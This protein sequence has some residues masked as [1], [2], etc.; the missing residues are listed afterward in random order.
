MTAAIHAESMTMPGDIEG[1]IV[2]AMAG[3]GFGSGD[4]RLGLALLANFIRLLGSE[5][6]PLPVAAVVCYNAGVKHLIQGSPLLAH[7]QALSARGIEIIACRTCVEYF[8]IEDALKVGRLG[9]M[10]EIQSL[11]LKHRTVVL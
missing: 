7:M 3:P 1:P 8:E 10:L 4:D 6:E 11:L 5:R 2:L 9:T